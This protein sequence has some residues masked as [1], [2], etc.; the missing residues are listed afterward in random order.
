[1]PHRARYPLLETK[2]TISDVER[3]SANIILD[4]DQTLISAIEPEKVAFLS[5]KSR[6]VHS[7]VMDEDYV[8]YHRP[9]LQELLDFLF[10]NFNVGIWTA[11]TQDYALFIVKEIILKDHPERVL[12]FVLSDQQCEL[13]DEMY[14]CIKDLRLIWDYLKIEGY[15][16]DN[17][18]ILDDNGD[19]FLT[20][21]NHALPIT[22]FHIDSNPDDKEL[23]RLITKLKKA[24]ARFDKKAQ[25]LIAEGL[26][27]KGK[28]SL[29]I[30][31]AVDERL[32]EKEDIEE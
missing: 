27:T 2:E 23:K 8:V 20:Q 7:S 25:D 31:D 17:T 9:H 5:K 24:K 13:A 1:M 10:A 29:L 16:K 21:L 18:F 19:V 30:K 15:N 4:L 22:P 6:K 26:H 14:G 28:T 32:L 11:A 12:D 3:K